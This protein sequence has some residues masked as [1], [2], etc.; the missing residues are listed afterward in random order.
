MDGER[1]TEKRRNGETEKRRKGEKETG[2]CV[3]EMVTS[4]NGICVRRSE[5]SDGDGNMRRYRVWE[6]WENE[7]AVIW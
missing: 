4:E 5:M 1:R 2:K 7:L 6:R 3:T